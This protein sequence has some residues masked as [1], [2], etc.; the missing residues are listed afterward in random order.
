MSI[1]KTAT[2]RAGKIAGDVQK[3]VRRARLEAER[4]TLERRHR[5]ALTEL[6]RHTAA[7]VKD[8]RLPDTDLGEQIA[9]VDDL[10]MLIAANDAEITDLTSSE[11]P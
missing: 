9:A 4:R 7:L 2:Q 6:G 1:V 8:G 3:S 10:V 11:G 5:A